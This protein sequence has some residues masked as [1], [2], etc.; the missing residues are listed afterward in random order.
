MKFC[1]EKT[2]MLKLNAFL[3]RPFSKLPI[4]HSLLLQTFFHYKRMPGIYQFRKKPADDATQILEKIFERNMH[5]MG[6]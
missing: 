6:A 1:D 3:E 2:Q 4:T 5:C